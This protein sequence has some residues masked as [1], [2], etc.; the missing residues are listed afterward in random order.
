[1]TAGGKVYVCGQGEDGQL[2]LG[3][4]TLST[5]KPLLLDTLKD[6][7]VTQMAVGISQSGAVTA[8]GELFLWG[9]TSFDVHFS[10]SLVEGLKGKRVEQVCVGTHHAAALAREMDDGRERER[11]REREDGRN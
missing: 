11:E 1:L 9:T 7:F 2:G 8:D 10:P 6:K 5:T 3:P 4:T